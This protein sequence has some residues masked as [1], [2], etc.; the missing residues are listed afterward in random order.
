MKHLRF[1]PLAF[2]ADV[3]GFALFAI[4]LIVLGTAAVAMRLREQLF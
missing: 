1:L 2:V 3:H 4:Y